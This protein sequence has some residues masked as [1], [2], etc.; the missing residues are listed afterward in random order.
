MDFHKYFNQLKKQD[1]GP[2]IR[3]AFRKKLL[4]LVVCAF[5][6]T[7]SI[8][9]YTQTLQAE[10]RAKTY[11]ASQLSFLCDRMQATQKSRVNLENKLADDM[12]S[13]AKSLARLLQAQPA[14]F[15]NSKFLGEFCQENSIDEINITNGKGLTVVSYPDF[16]TDLYDFAAYPETKKYMAIL[17]NKD[18]ILAEPLRLSAYSHGA[19]FKYVGVA[20]LDAPGII[21]LGVGG[22]AYNQYMSAASLQ[23][24]VANYLIGDTGA[25]YIFDKTGLAEGATDIK[26]SGYSLEQL[27]LAQA[28]AGQ[29]NGFFTATPLAGEP[30]LCGF[31]RYGA[32]TVVVTYPLSEVYAKRNSLLA[33]N[34]ALY[35]MLFVAVYIL[36]SL[37]L[38]SSIVKNIFS[39]N[40]SLADITQGNLEEKVNV[41]AFQEFDMLSNSINT[42][43]DALKI[44]IAEAAARLDREL[45]IARIIQSSSLPNKFPP[46][47]DI[48]NFSIFANM[49]MATQVG[50]DFYDFFLIGK[51]LGFV[52][53]DVSGHGIPAAL[54]MMTARTQIKN[55]MLEDGDLGEEFARINNLLCSNNKA[56]M[57]VT[58]FAGVLDYTTGKVTCLNAGHN[59]P[60]L[61]HKDGSFAWVKGRSGLVMGSM[62]DMQYKPFSLQLESEDILFLYTDGITEAVNKQDEQFG[63]AS[64]QQVLQQAKTQDVEQLAA[65]V[66][67]AVASFTEGLEPTDDRTMLALQWHKQ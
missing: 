37:L 18:L 43:V 9:Y 2:T 5:A 40:K 26:R 30:S 45:E 62:P 22:A 41:R 66:K 33:W 36:I 4:L 1:Q 44:A 63:D 23:N 46:W 34:G 47:P 50:G 48:K 35:F 31:D 53:A 3:S 13:D 57:F 10:E 19:Y 38:E 11:L 58:V 17:K 7:F 27:G 51:K 49:Q 54:F 56:M 25:A 28:D 15:T 55:H 21:Q 20:R 16:Y 8:A 42:T 65:R 12:V 39:V 6:I 67:E 60:L 59:K 32:Y 24:M 64:L 14:L 52:M 29:L 61:G